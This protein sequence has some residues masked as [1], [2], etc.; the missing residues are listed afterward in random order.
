MNTVA[1]GKTVNRPKTWHY[2]VTILDTVRETK[3]SK[4]FITYSGLI[5]NVG[6]IIVIG[7]EVNFLA[8]SVIV[9]VIRNDRLIHMKDTD[10]TL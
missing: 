9:L 10:G 1:T 3:D 7:P 8:V 6:D 5:D 4:I 2:K